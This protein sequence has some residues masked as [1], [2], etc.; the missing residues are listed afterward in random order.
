MYA[1]ILKGDLCPICTT[2]K[3]I[4]LTNHL[5][6][7]SEAN[8]GPADPRQS[9][10][11]FWAAKAVKWGVLDG[12]ARTR[13]CMNCEHYIATS[14]VVECMKTGEG[15]KLKASELPIEGE[16]WADIPGMPSAAC[17]RYNITCSALRTCDDWEAGG[18]I[19]DTVSGD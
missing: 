7:I 14:Q 13:L 4:S 5:I 19:T 15:A 1:K 8:L 11:V 9:S 17:S 2:S 16:T 3:S 12:E 18:P 10:P 6:C